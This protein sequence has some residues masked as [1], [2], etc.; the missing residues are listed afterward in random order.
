[1]VFNVPAKAKRKPGRPASFGKAQLDGQPTWQS[2]FGLPATNKRL[3]GLAEK[4]LNSSEITSGNYPQGQPL[5]TEA[6]RGLTSYN[7]S[8][9]HCDGRQSHWSTRVPDQPVYQGRFCII[10]IKALSDLDDIIHH[11][12]ALQCHRYRHGDVPTV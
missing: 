11:T 9:L 2:L 1:L 10:S 12:W 4:L 6:N 8:Q 3:S 7:Q 5:T